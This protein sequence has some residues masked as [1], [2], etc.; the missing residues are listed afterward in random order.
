MESWR[1]TS[2]DSHTLFVSGRNWNKDG[3]NLMPEALTSTALYTNWLVE[4]GPCLCQ[5]LK[6]YN[7]AASLGVARELAGREGK[8]AVRCRRSNAAW[9]KCCPHSLNAAAAAQY[10]PHAYQLARRA[11]RQVA[12]EAS[13][14]LLRIFACRESIDTDT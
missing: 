8:T 13:D 6:R 1:Q 10:E 11:I 4:E 5:Q 14:K 12:S 7:I 9:R 2:P 3:L